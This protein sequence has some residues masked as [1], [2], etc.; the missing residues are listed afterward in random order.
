MPKPA[1]GSS[2]N[3]RREASLSEVK[4]PTLRVIGGA[5]R[6]VLELNE[7]ARVR[8]RC[9]TELAIVPWA[10]QLFEELG[11]LEEVAQT[12]AGLYLRWVA[13][14]QNDVRR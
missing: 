9:S 2:N 11:V 5:D 3:A 12:A 6:Q 1:A 10:T 8:L 14:E 13:P 4:A 7:W